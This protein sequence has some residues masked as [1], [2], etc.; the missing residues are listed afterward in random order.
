M[1]CHA[2]GFWSND[3]QTQI[4]RKKIKKMSKVACRYCKQ[5]TFSINTNVDY[6]TGIYIITIKIKSQA[7]DLTCMLSGMISRLSSR[8]HEI[9]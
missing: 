9:N 2:K 3:G 1:M 6:R 8:S 5:P 7:P 4:D